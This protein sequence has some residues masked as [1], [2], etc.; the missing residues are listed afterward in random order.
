MRRTAILPWINENSP[1]KSEKRNT[2]SLPA[3]AAV[4]NSPF[5]VSIVENTGPFRQWDID[6]SFELTLWSEVDTLLKL[7]T[8][9]F[10]DPTS[11]LRL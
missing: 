10:D 8:E 2:A 1:W 3:I 4:E 5:L 9:Q 11:I 7:K 6:A